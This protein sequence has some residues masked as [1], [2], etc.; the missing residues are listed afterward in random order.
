VTLLPRSRLEAR[1][2]LA[3]AWDMR[4]R[5]TYAMRLDR[6]PSREELPALLNARGLTGI[7][8]EVGVRRGTYSHLLLWNWKGEKLIS[9]DPWL[10]DAPG[11][12]VDKS[13][14]SQG[15]H[16]RLY[17]D[18]KQRLAPFGPRSEIWR[19]TS[20]RAAERL[21][22]GSIDF[23]YIDA[24]HDYDSVLEDLR[25]WFPKVRGGGI[26]SGHDYVTGCFPQGEFGVSA[27]VDQFFGALGIPV[28]TTQARPPADPFPTWLVQIPR[29]AG[30]LRQDRLTP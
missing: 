5:R 1:R 18:T 9:I 19:L 30:S 22:D 8:A 3:R 6:I 13:N 7:G 14:V 28:F 10:E 4:F 17:E 25:A 20:V 11:A 2:K 12:Y 27:A 26:L 24:R 21:D 23:V 15:E 16:E 29:A